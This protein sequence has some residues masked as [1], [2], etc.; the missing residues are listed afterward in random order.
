MRFRNLT[1]FCCIALFAACSNEGAA[2]N[3]QIDLTIGTDP[4]TTS[5]E[6]GFE[7]DRVDYRITCAGTV[8]G[9]LPIPPDSTGGDYDY[10]DS[11]DISGSFE[12]VDDQ[13][14]LTPPVWTT[15]TNLPPGDCTATLVVFRDGTV[16]CE[17]SQDFTVVEDATTT[18]DISLVCSLAIDLPDGMGDTDGDFQFDVGNV[19]PKIFNFSPIPRVIPDGD[20]STIIQ[21]LAFD[22]DG[23]CGDR[24]DPQTCDFENPPNCIPGPD[25]GLVPTLSAF[26]G[27]FDD[28]NALI[29]HYN[30]DPYFP[31]PIEICV[32]VSDGDLDCDKSA[33]TVVVCPDPCKDVVCIDDNNECT[34]EYCD[35]ALGQ[36]VSEIAPDGIAC[37][38]CQYTC[39]VGVCDPGVP[40]VGI[41]TG[42]NMPFTGL[43][44]TIVNQTYVNPYTGFMFSK[45]GGAVNHNISTYEGDGSTAIDTIFG[46]PMGDW[47]LLN[48]PTVAPQTV[49]GVEQFVMGNSGDFAHFADKFI[50]TID[51]THTGGRGPDT[52]WANGGDDFLDGQ[53]GP[54][55]LDG[56]PGNDQVSGARGPD[57]IT[58]GRTHGFDSISGGQGEDTLTIN[59]LQSQIL[60]AP[61]VN[62]PSYQFDI[63]YVGTLLAEVTEVEVLELMDGSIDL[64]ACVGGVCTLCGDD[65]LNGGEE[66]DDGNLT[67]G[68]GC[69][70]DCTVE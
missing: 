26:V 2:G 64:M 13:D 68:D 23:T 28:P 67:N 32:D 33:C 3:T 45:S 21:T 42:P 12:I 14:D 11:V 55:L 66:C 7:A 44:P 30:C 41:Q 36:C 37:Q 54:D 51:M 34:A 57:H 47:L 31:G 56:G 39:D 61:S 46:T 53:D 24:C 29:A 22:L 19:C 1:A 20:S 9:T 4:S 10:G 17:G 5:E 52:I 58:M 18:V 6:L 69:A 40:F 62:S 50:V 65:A 70:S 63:Y 59:A 35:P 49:C 38:N 25:V 8:P 15:V 27:T 43:S 16:V 48:D 60:I